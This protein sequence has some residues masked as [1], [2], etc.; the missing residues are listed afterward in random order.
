MKRGTVISLIFGTVFFLAAFFVMGNRGNPR[1]IKYVKLGG[2]SVRVDLALS[3][4]AQEKGLAGKDSLDEN[5]GMLFVFSY[6]ATRYFWMK[7]MNFPIDIIWLVPSEGGEEKE[8]KVIYIK[9]NASPE[10]PLLTFGPDSPSKYVLEVAAGFLDK[11]NLKEGD[12]VL[13]TY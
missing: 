9:K 1:A 7:D 8:A 5:E 12:S 10:T 11:N 4:E 3:K 13:F 2:Q 6:P